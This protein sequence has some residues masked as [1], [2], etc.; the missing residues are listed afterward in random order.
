MHTYVR[1]KGNT[2][3]KTF[4]FRLKFFSRDDYYTI[5]VTTKYTGLPMEINRVKSRK[6]SL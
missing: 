4:S 3:K 2:I 5:Q 1:H 6:S